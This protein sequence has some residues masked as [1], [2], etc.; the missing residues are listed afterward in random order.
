MHNKSKKILP[1]KTL[2]VQRMLTCNATI[3]MSDYMTKYVQ[4]NITC[5]KTIPH[6]FDLHNSLN[7]NLL[8]DPF[9]INGFQSKRKQ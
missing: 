2:R 6:A 5:Y 8:L 9:Q 4:G 3:K 7:Y 1:H